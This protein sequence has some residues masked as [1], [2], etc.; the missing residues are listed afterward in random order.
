MTNREYEM[1]NGMILKTA[2]AVKRWYPQAI[3]CY[4]QIMFRTRRGQYWIE[5]TTL[6]ENDKKRQ[7]AEYQDA[8][9]AKRWFETNDIQA[10]DELK[11]L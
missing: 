2:S 3:A 7:R 1:S 5:F 9:A 11:E 4:D 8:R 6:D 10:P